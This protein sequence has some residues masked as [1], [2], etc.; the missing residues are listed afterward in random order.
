MNEIVVRGQGA[1][2][3][4]E[5]PLRRDSYAMEIDRGRNCYTCG[6]FGHMAHHCRNREGGRPIEGRRVEYGGGRIK[7]VNDYNNLKEIENLELLD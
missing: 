1:G 5:A 4:V 7:K 2:Q 6:G 3:N